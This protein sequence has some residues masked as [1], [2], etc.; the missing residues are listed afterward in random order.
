MPQK[1]A[2]VTYDGKTKRIANPSDSLPDF[3]QQVTKHFNVR[4][5]RLLWDDQSLW[6]STS[7]ASLQKSTQAT[8]VA[9]DAQYKE[10]IAKFSESNPRFILVAADE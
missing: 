2:K 6:M 8:E 3:L 4:H 5:P 7:Q 9:T 10:I 1:W